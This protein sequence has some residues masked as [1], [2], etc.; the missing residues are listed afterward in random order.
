MLELDFEDC[1]QLAK[2][3][4]WFDAVML[5]NTNENDV[6]EVLIPQELDKQCI[7]DFIILLTNPF[8]DMIDINRFLAETLIN[9]ESVEAFFYF[10][11]Y[12][13]S[14]N[15]LF[16]IMQVLLDFKMSLIANLLKLSLMHYENTLY[17]TDLFRILQN[18]IGHSNSNF[19]QYMQTN[20]TEEEILLHHK[21]VK[22]PWNILV[23]RDVRWNV[24]KLKKILRNY[25]R[26]LHSPHFIITF[27]ESDVVSYMD[28]L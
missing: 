4:A 25:E 16:I 11:S 10:H 28:N 24:T 13:C 5:H 1:K 6:I 2:R 20:L 14:E 27:P 17:T 8:T 7:Y 18:K 22:Q 9:A 19:I 15:L 12:F 21:V 23:Q 26:S 3:L